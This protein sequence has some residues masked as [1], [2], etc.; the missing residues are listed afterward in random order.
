MRISFLAVFSLINLSSFSVSRSLTVLL[1][2]RTSWGINRAKAFPYSFFSFWYVVRMILP[3]P[4]TMTIPWTFLWVCIRLRVSSTS[5]IWNW[6]YNATQIIC[7]NLIYVKRPKEA[8]D[9]CSS[10]ITKSVLYLINSPALLRN[11]KPTHVP[12]AIILSL[13]P[14]QLGPWSHIQTGGIEPASSQHPRCN[15]F[16]WQIAHPLQ[17]PSS[18]CL[19]VGRMLLQKWRFQKSSLTFLSLQNI[20]PECSFPI[21][22]SKGTNDEQ[23]LLTMSF[24]FGIASLKCTI[25]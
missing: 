6:F 24:S 9:I 18:C 13:T 7:L 4:F 21:V 11:P 15:I 23:T 8:N 3:S 25:Q 19:F 1:A 16:L 2:L 17:K 22:G 20:I 10:K 5:A 12:R 14:L